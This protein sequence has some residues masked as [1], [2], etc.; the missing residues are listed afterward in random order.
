MVERPALIQ[1]LNQDMERGLMLICAPAGYGKTTLISA[2][3][4]QMQ[5]KN[6]CLTLDKQDDDPIRFLTY[7]AAALRK[8]D[9]SIGEALEIQLQTCPLPIL[10]NCLTPVINK[11]NEFERPFWL[12]LDDYHVIN[13]RN[14]HQAIRFL[15]NH[16]PHNFHLVIA[17]RADPP[18]PLSKYRTK[19]EMLELRLADLRFSEE[20]AVDFFNQ[21]IGMTFSPDDINMLYDKTEGWAAGLLMAGLSL[22][23]RQDPSKYI[24][25][26]FGE[27]RYIMDFLFDEIFSGQS[28]EIQEFLLQTSILERLCGALCNAVTAQDNSQFILETLERNNQFLIPLDDRYEWYRYHHLFRDLLI[29]RANQLITG[30]ISQLH[31]RAGRWFRDHRLLEKA[32]E[33]FLLAQD[34]ENVATIIEKNIQNFDLQNQQSLL[35]AWLAQIPQPILINHP[36]LCVYRAWGDYWSG[37][38]GKEEEWLKL[39]EQ[40]IQTGLPDSKNEIE[41]LQGHIA[42]AR[43]HLALIGEDIPRA[44]SMGEKALQLLPIDDIR[45]SEAAIA[46]AGVYWALGDVK[47]TQR[48]FEMAV[49]T[50]LKINYTSM[51]AGCM[52]YVGIQLIKQGKLDEASITFDEGLKI[53]TLSY[54][55]ETPMAGFLNIRLGDLWREY[56]N[57]RL[58]E[59]YLTKGLEQSQYLGQPDILVDATI[60]CGRFQLAI[61]N[62]DQANYFHQKSKEIAEKT[63]V[64]PWISCWLNDL[65]I[66]IWSSEENWD[67]INHWINTCGLSFDQSLSYQ[68]DLNHQNLARA[69]IARASLSTADKIEGSV[70]QLLDKLLFAAK[71][72]GWVHEQIKILIMEAISLQIQGDSQ[73]ALKP[74]IKAVVLAEPSGYQRVFIDEGERM[75]ALLGQL[76]KLIRIGDLTMLNLVKEHANQDHVESIQKYIHFLL[77]AFIRTKP[78]LKSSAYQPIRGIETG[79]IL[80]DSLTPR[81]IDVL[82]LLALGYPDRKIANALFITQGTVHKHLKNI[83]SKLDV[84]S[85]TEA[86]ARA[87]SLKILSSS[88]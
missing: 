18:L 44:K 71:I 1:K 60:C 50:A 45:R 66:R 15:L 40:S 81:E 58:A 34:F 22:Q 23:T 55:N 83:Y 27:D 36:W 78:Q 30:E 21:V 26:F 86:V 76:E 59:H 82:K 61:G 65:K 62:L 47:N 32:I 13:D 2:W 41:H 85:R 4:H 35:S 14:N 7:L 43:A 53:A 24:R 11:I 17:T 57:L 9:P 84:H 63:K 6:T 56:N 72:A 16:R 64:D 54:G 88:Q 29:I 52:G 77:K 25:S 79:D 87:Q 39:A 46:L 69:Y 20:E 38:R 48:S 10:E 19:S 80:I 67:A 75:H 68:H 70:S 31:S 28:K 73:K 42:A 37:N 33:H 51:A 49:D 5:Q 74:L 3:L 8:I 12:V